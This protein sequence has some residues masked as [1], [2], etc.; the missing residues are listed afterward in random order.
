MADL[1]DLF[2]NPFT[3]GNQRL[4]IGAS[5]YVTSDDSESSSFSQAVKEQNS[6][7]MCYFEGN[8]NDGFNLTINFDQWFVNRKLNF[9]LPGFLILQLSWQ[10]GVDPM[11]Q[12]IHSKN[13]TYFIKH[14]LTTQNGASLSSMRTSLSFFQGLNSYTKNTINMVAFF[15]KNIGFKNCVCPNSNS[16]PNFRIK[17][18]KVLYQFAAMYHIRMSSN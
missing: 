6:A 9:I 13:Y 16:C 5:F 12:S 7:E 10:N 2:K 3:D 4:N 15:E 1:K 8:L 14:E 17:Q 18:L 11:T